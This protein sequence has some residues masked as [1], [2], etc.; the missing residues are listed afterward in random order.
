MRRPRAGFLPLLL[1]VAAVSGG[2]VADGPP[3]R[4]WAAS[5][6]SALN[7][8]REEISTLT[9]RAQQ[10]TPTSTTPQ[11]AKENLVRML[12]G[13]R[14]ASEKARGRIADAGVPEVDDGDAIAGGVTGSLAK[15]RDA[16][17]RAG[18]TVRTL[19][20]D[21]PPAFYQGVSTAMTTLQQEYDASA[22]DT[23]QLRST[24][25]QQAFGE[26]PECL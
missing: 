19:S 14:D 20:T 26:V 4:V 12:E 17:G 21:D 6:C 7:P 5:V 3:P 1:V 11:Q 24:E 8:W 18:E 15:V 13:A 25:L 16:Y 10:Q 2:C 23:S 22:L 9:T